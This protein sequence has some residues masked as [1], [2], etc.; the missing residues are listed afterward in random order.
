VQHKATAA[1]EAGLDHVRAA[2]AEVG[3]LELIVRRPAVDEREVLHTAELS[4]DEGLVGDTWRVRG[5]SRTA[6][7]SSH[8][9]MQLNVMNA[10]AAHLVAGH[11]DR[12]ALA[13]D[14]LYLDL[15]ISEENLPP[16]TRL[17]LGDAVIEITDQPHTRCAKFAA[18]FG[19]DALRFVNSLVGRQLRLRGMNARVVVPGRITRGAEVRKIPPPARS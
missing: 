9:D 15:D 16:G 6:D 14:Q 4:R 13:G 8:P 19:K 10:R 5:S 1:L 18:R 7:G 17:A 2:P 3:R 12:W 11:E